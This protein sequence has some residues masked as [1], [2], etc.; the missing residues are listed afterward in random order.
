MSRWDLGI[1]SKYRIKFLFTILEQNLEHPVFIV[2]QVKCNVTNGK[3]HECDPSSIFFLKYCWLRY[4]RYTLNVTQAMPSSY[5]RTR[6]RGLLNRPICLQK[7]FFAFHLGHIL[8]KARHC[9]SQ[10]TVDM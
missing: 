3:R 1:S 4:T 5:F 7:N 2:T 9:Q 10:T 8:K 6:N